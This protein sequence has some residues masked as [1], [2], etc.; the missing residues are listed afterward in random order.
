MNEELTLAIEELRSRSTNRVWFIPVL[1]DMC[2][3]P[4]RSIGA[5]ETLLDLQWVDLHSDYE[6][7]L[8]KITGI[9]LAN[10][11]EI[12]KTELRDRASWIR[13]KQRHGS[14]AVFR[15]EANYEET[16]IKL[17]EKYGVEYD[18]LRKS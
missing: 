15:A 9:I 4:A 16:R 11:I 8:K 7:G 18:P 12:A 17:F 10:D 3:V 5:G 2:D 6:Q 1:L 14:P 13:K